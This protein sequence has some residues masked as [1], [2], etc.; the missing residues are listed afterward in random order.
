MKVGGNG[1]IGV[2]RKPVL[3]YIIPSCYYSTTHLDPLPPY[4]VISPL[5]PCIPNCFVMNRKFPPQISFCKLTI[6]SCFFFFLWVCPDFYCAYYIS[7]CI[8]SSHFIF[9]LFLSIHQLTPLPIYYSSSPCL[10]LSHLSLLLHLFFCF[11]ALS[12][13]SYSRLPSVIFLFLS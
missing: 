2:G 9:S 7:S 3:L 10:S 4:H 1:E 8:F 6:S 5:W 12:I 11:S 13:S